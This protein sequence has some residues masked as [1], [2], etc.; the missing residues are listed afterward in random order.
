MKRISTLRCSSMRITNCKKIF[1][2]FLS[3]LFCLL[4]TTLVRSGQIVAR[5]LNAKTG[6][7]TTVQISP[8]IEM[9]SA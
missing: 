9:L 2:I 3:V 4:V 1:P 5:G 8:K 6:T 7:E